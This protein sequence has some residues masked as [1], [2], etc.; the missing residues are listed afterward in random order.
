MSCHVGVSHPLMRSCDKLQAELKNACWT[1]NKRGL[2]WKTLNTSYVAW[3]WLTFIYV[4][5]YN[6]R[7]LNNI[8]GGASCSSA[9]MLLRCM[10]ARFSEVRGI[11]PSSFV[12]LREHMF[13]SASHRIDC[14]YTF[15]GE[16]MAPNMDDCRAT[17]RQINVVLQSTCHRQVH[18]S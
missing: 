13:C 15:D 9:E 5:A 2:Q 8:V 12:G 10:C 18:V 16:L 14:S 17:E 4:V 11:D 7:C 6:R 1:S 3:R